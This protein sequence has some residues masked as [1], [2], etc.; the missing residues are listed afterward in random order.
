[1]KPARLVAGDVQPLEL[2]DELTAVAGEPAGQVDVAVAGLRGVA[3]LG[4]AAVPRADVLADVAAVHLRPERRAVLL[5]DR[6]RRLRPVRQ[7]ARRVER[8]GLVER[9]GRARVDAE[10]ALAAIGVERRRRL[11]LDG[12]DERAEHDPRAMPP[13]DQHRVLAVEPDA[14]PRRRLTVD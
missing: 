12:R 2:V 13:R 1:A 4:H 14:A 10:P 6:R 8:P 7:A 5:R 9:T 3:P 11:E